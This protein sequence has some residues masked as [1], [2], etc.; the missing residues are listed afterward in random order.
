MNAE[1]IQKDWVL[2]IEEM[3]RRYD[4]DTLHYN[5]PGIIFYMGQCW[6]W[7]TWQSK[8]TFGSTEPFFLFYFQDGACHFEQPAYIGPGENI[9]AQIVKEGS[10]WATRSKK[11]YARNRKTLYDWMVEHPVL[12]GKSLTYYLD[13]LHQH[14]K[15]FLKSHIHAHGTIYL[16]KHIT[17]KVLEAF[18]GSKRTKPEILALCVS[19]IKRDPTIHSN[20]LD[21]FWIWCKKNHIFLTKER[22]AQNLN[23]LKFRS[24]LQKCFDAG[25]F[26]NA[27]Y[28][29][30]QLWTLKDEYELLLE[31]KPH[32][33]SFVPKKP[34]FHITSKQRDWIRIAQQVSFLR[35]D[36]KTMQQRAFCYQAQILEKIAV[37]RGIPR[38][39]LEHLRIN[40]LTKEVLESPIL[41]SIIAQ[42]KQGYLVFWTPEK[43]FF[44]SD[45]K[46]AQEMFIAISE[47]KTEMI[48]EL[49][50]QIAYPGK[51]KGIVR[52][53]LNPR[54]QQNF[55]EG[56]ILVTGM[57]SPDFVPL[58]GKAGGFVT[59]LGGVTCHAAIIARE[60]KKPCVIGTKTATKVF[61]DGDLVEVD[62]DKGIVRKITKKG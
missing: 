19:D 7:L 14:H 15:I 11:R 62:A 5:Y 28:G 37:I 43:G 18:Q 58:L 44:T 49:H 45:G 57:T 12:D 38:N 55:H 1:K 26:L 42:Q 21:S 35:D 17:E 8:E 24:R 59:E 40:Q 34:S 39:E 4:K 25:Y 27:G 6:D 51:V 48:E 61:K 9:I 33:K 50:G 2:R 23:N 16:D 54:T 30:V 36:R 20:K 29:G 47:A 10:K 13:L 60:L 53:V 41:Q 56:D 22:F 3:R 46:K 52:I 32:K 31:H